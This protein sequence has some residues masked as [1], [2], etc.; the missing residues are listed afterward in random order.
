MK[1]ARFTFQ[2][3]RSVQSVIGDLVAWAL[4]TV[5]RQYA[6]CDSFRPCVPLII[7]LVIFL[8]HYCVW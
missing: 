4:T 2:T 6:A 8:S 5:Q 7:G 3:R 1:D